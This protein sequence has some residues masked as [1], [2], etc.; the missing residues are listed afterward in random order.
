MGSCSRLSLDRSR[1]LER[2]QAHDH[3]FD[4]AAGNFGF[5]DQLLALMLPIVSSIFQQAIL[6]IQLF[7]QLDEITDL[8]LK[9]LELLRFHGDSTDESKLNLT[10]DAASIRVNAAKAARFQQYAAFYKG[11]L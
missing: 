10:I 1:L 4:F 6:P 7:A 5:L 11:L 9:E 8:A 3:R 2:L